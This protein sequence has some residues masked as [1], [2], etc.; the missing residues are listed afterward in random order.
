MTRTGKT[1]LI[2]EDNVLNMKLIKAIL[3]AS[4]FRVLSAGNGRDAMA[5]ARDDRPDVVL[6]D[7]QLPEASGLEV[8]RWFKADD[9]LAGIPVVA[10]SAFLDDLDQDDVAAAGFAG[11]CAKPV[12]AANLLA[13]LRAVA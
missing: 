4:G 1:V 11:T 10:V 6:M 7:V 12:A 9:A 2:V 13:T 5:M 8:T 3:D